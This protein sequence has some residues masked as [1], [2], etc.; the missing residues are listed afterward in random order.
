MRN[1]FRGNYQPNGYRD[2]K[3][4]VELGLGDDSS[5]PRRTHLCEVQLH[6][7]PFFSLKEGNHKIYEWAR[8]LQVRHRM[9]PQQLF[10]G[11]RS[12]LLD[13]MIRLAQE[14]WSGLRRFALADLL[15]TARRHDEAGALLQEVWHTE[16]VYLAAVRLAWVPSLASYPAG[17]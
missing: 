5:V 8:E 9:D 10:K 12:E 16:P 4:I 17:H 6:F 2:I 14:D 15:T 1:T 3:L 13:E 11:M 7:K